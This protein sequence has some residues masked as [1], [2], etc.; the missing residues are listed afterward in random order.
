MRAHPPSAADEA[1]AQALDA[2]VTRIIETVLSGWDYNRPLHS[3]NKSDLRR[4][5]EAA[6]CGWILK[7]AEQAACGDEKAREELISGAFIVG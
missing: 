2:A 4:I 7:R 1:D 3:L 5:A 6:I